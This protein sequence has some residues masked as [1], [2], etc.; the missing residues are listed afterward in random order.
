[1]PPIES[2]IAAARKL[3]KAVDKLQ[4][5]EPVTHVYNPLDYAWAAHEQYLRKMNPTGT[6]VLFLGMNPGPWGM[7]QTGVPFGQ[8]EAVRD[9]LAID[10][11]ITHPKREHPKRP[12]EGLACTRSEVSGERLW[13][14]FRQ[15][16]KSSAKFFK[17]HFV[18]NYC[19]LV[20]MQASGKN[21]TP[22]KLPAAERQSLDTICDAHLRALIK[23]TQPKWAVG[24]GVYAEKC[25]QRVAPSTTKIARILHPS[26][27]SPAANRGWPEAATTQLIEAGIWKD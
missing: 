19:P 14:L 4:F 9:W 10:G 16:F 21:H 26:P 3:S 2:A 24:I 17:H 15:R 27:A 12:I 5:S 20:F 8:I 25:L 6:R 18:A 11:I 1:M 13:G 7:A 23:A 22:D